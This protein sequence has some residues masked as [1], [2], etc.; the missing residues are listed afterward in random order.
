ML[1]DVAGTV[2]VAAV[3]SVGA[4]CRKVMVEGVRRT[5]VVTR[6]RLEAMVVELLKVADAMLSMAVPG[7]VAARVA[8][9]RNCISESRQRSSKAMLKRR[10]KS[11][12]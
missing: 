3:G 6:T 1:K 8:V 5:I 12:S 4:Y 11:Q 2:M 9:G 7:S 10:L